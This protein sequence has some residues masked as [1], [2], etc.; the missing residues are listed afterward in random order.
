MTLD[1]ELINS[2]RTDKYFYILNKNNSIP[3]PKDIV[4]SNLMTQ[5]YLT[6]KERAYLILIRQSYNKI[7]K[8]DFD[9]IMPSS[10][11]KMK[12]NINLLDNNSIFNFNSNTM[13]SQL[14]NKYSIPDI[15]TLNDWILCLEIICNGLQSLDGDNNILL[16]A[17][18]LQILETYFLE[19]DEEQCK[20]ILEKLINYLNSSLLCE[21][22]IV[23]IV[24]TLLGLVS[25][26]KSLV[27]CEQN[28]MMALLTL[29]KLYGDPRGR[30]ALGV[31]WELFVT[32]RLSII[33]RLQSKY[34]DAEYVEELFDAT[35]FNL[36][37]N[38]F[39][40]YDINIYFPLINLIVLL[41]SI[42]FMICRS[43]L[44]R[45]PSILI[46]IFIL[47]LRKI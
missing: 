8:Y 7:Q 25:E 38:R 6:I 15:D 35:S 1:Y 27:E 41:T 45:I 14:K 31:P 4:S 39:N 33:T 43:N 32:W 18:I 40:K 21:P 16:E 46:N 19:Q 17:Y 24:H 47:P 12:N 22:E 3:S 9:L 23:V 10:L 11:Y 13:D 37:K 34:T 28:Y 2:I 44:M 26:T 42:I 29:H 20:I 30:G 5:T 36:K